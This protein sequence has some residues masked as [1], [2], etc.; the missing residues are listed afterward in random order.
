MGMEVMGQQM[1]SIILEVLSNLSDS[2]ETSVTQ[3]AGAPMSRAQ[4]KQGRTQHR[5][6]AGAAPTAGS[7][8]VKHSLMTVISK[9]TSNLSVNSTP[10]TRR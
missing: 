1:N 8:W 10:P 7:S 3:N 9:S 6:Q 4:G 2:M 5:A